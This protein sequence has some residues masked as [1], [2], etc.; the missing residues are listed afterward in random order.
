MR[1]AESLPARPPAVALEE[2]EHIAFTGRSELAHGLFRSLSGR[3]QAEITSQYVLAEVI[4]GGIAKLRKLLGASAEDAAREEKEF[5]DGTARL[6]ISA[7]RRTSTRPRGLFETLLAWSAELT[8]LSLLS[9]ALAG[10]EEMLKLGIE[11]YPD[12]G[13][14]CVLD[15]AELLHVMGRGREARPMLGFLADRPYLVPSRDLVAEIFIGLA[16][17]ALAA[18]D[19][20]AYRDAL[21]RGLRHFYTSIDARQNLF[22]Q[23]AKS[24]RRSYRAL[25]DRRVR[26][27]DRGLFLLHWTYFRM[28]RSRFA[29]AVGLAA[30]FRLALLGCT[31]A[32]SY[33]GR[34]ASPALRPKQLG[35]VPAAEAETTTPGPRWR[36]RRR[37]FLVTRAMG[38]I[39]DLLMMTPGFHALKKANPSEEI[40][41]AIPKRYFPVFDGNTDVTCLDIE[42]RALDPGTFRRWFDFTDCPAARVES[43]TAPRVQ[44]S[45]ID[46]FA[47]ALG[48][49]WLELRGMDRRPRYIVTGAERDAQRSF[50][51][52][53]GLEGKTVVGV[54]LRSDEVYRDYPFVEEVVQAV[55]RNAPVLVFDAERIAG[56][57]GQNVVKVEGLPMRH[58][59]ALAA[60]CSALIVPDSAFVHLAGALDIPC[61]SIYGPIDGRVRTLHYPRT[62]FLDARGSLDCIP[63]WRNDKIP[64]RLTNQRASAC[65]GSV[66]AADVRA[67]LARVLAGA[68]P[69]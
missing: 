60:A 41:L 29:R 4:Q 56:F 7:C 10:Y 24:Y 5:I 42:D 35:T 18:G 62:V 9:E 8:R 27:Q 52:T 63:C 23:L 67:A 33:S 22:T 39:G 43:R 36:S 3:E 58:A 44:R 26:A 38:G 65:L 69:S 30:A 11:R 61:V 16:R 21:T 46:I 59:F 40:H 55:S 2:L 1:V 51:A 17:E 12:L 48:L 50:W 32:I 20:E 15:K 64:C 28:R 13:V 6:F 53:H 57:D 54:Q 47:S 25:L 34:S 45:R 68:P 19:V 66:W 49:G 37:D 14:R 31:Y